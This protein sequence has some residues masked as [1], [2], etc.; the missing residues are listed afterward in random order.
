[1]L[2]CSEDRVKKI[3]AEMVV[4]VDGKLKKGAVHAAS[5]SLSLRHKV[6]GRVAQCSRRKARCSIR[7]A[8]AP[9][10]NASLLSLS[11]AGEQERPEIERT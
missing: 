1:V 4:I 5:E 11:L 7:K 3:L 6:D 2:Q 10:C 8:R 9:H